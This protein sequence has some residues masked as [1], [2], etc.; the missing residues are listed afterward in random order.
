MF[1]KPLVI[2][3][4]SPGVVLNA[5]FSSMI[6]TLPPGLRIWRYM[7]IDRFRD[8]VQGKQICFSNLTTMDDTNDGCS[9][10]GQKS[11]VRSE[12]PADVALVSNGLPERDRRCL[13]VSCWTDVPPEDGQR[14]WHEYANGGNGGAI[15][16]TVGRLRS[17]VGTEFAIGRVEY[18]VNPSTY[19][20][21]NNN[22]GDIAGHA[23]WKRPEYTWEREIRVL[24]YYVPPPVYFRDFDNGI[25]SDSQLP[26]RILRDVDIGALVC[27]FRIGNGV[28]DDEGADL[29]CAMSVALNRAPI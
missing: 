26:E 7:C 14:F 23:L 10:E 2:D 16:T 15:G 25:R 12:L 18:P 24:T 27:D 6:P 4:K 3:N 11:A 21:G 20:I 17:I 28:A 13:F 22:G 8:L 29:H 19:R 1:A 9:P 5:S